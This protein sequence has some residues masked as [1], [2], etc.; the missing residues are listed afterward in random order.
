MLNASPTSHG[1]NDVSAKYR[2][3]YFYDWSCLPLWSAN[4]AA[5]NEFG[6]SIDLANLP[7]S[8]RTVARVHLMCAWHDTALHRDDPTQQ[9][10]WDA[11]ECDRF[12]AAAQQLLADLE[13]ELGSDF[14]IVDQFQRR[15]PSS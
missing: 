15:T 3:R 13:S 12:N 11:D 1:L 10:P 8:A 5:R 7:L 2:L 14:E 6:Y 9:G 4:D